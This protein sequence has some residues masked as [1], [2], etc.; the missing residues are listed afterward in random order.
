MAE[1]MII[2]ENNIVT[3]IFCGDVEENENIIILPDNHQV[4]GG[5]SLEYYN[6]DFTRK[7][8]AE[9]IR[10]GLEECPQ[11]YILDGD[12]VRELNFEERIIAGL[13]PLPAYQKIVDGKLINKT[14]EEIWAEKTPDEKASI[15]RQKRDSLL[16]E[17]DTLLLKY[18]EQVELGI[19]SENKNYYTALLQYKQALRDIPEQAD[20]PDNIKYPIL[21]K[22]DEYE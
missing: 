14:E 13:D 12:T 21:P 8:E 3:G 11:G 20:F 7:S 9:L 16:N 10:L 5:E 2:D 17:V 19:V 15:I 1:Y 4:R 22:Y 6:E 18:T